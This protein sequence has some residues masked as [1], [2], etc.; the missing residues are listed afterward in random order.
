MPEVTFHI[1]WPDGVEERCYSPSTVIRQHLRA[2]QS[3]PLPSFMAHVRAGL[4]EASD[5]VE[6]KYGFACSSATG[7]LARLEDAARR[8]DAEAATVTCLSLE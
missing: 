7:Q 1:R 2:G 4:M 5:R 3:Y 6:A 8:Y